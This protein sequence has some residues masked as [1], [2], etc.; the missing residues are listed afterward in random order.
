MSAPPGAARGGPLHVGIVCYPS[1]GG[2]GVVAAE[3]G[4]GLARRGHSVHFISYDAPFRL[5]GYMTQVAFHGVEVPNYPLFK[6][7]PYLLALAS[8]IIEVARTQGLDLVHAH[9]AIPH[10]VS[11]YLA[12]KA[13]SDRLCVI[14]T[15]HGTDT[16]L[17][18]SDPAFSPLVEFCIA[19][20]D[21]VTV[22]SEYLRRRTR[23]VFGVTRDIEVV[24]NFVDPAEYAA[25]PDPALRARFAAPGEAIVAHLS[26]F[27]PVKRVE[28]VVR[29]FA[30]LVERHP[31]RLLMIGDGP[32][33]PRAHE[34]AREL[35]VLGRI[36]F[37]G[38]VNCVAPLLAIADAFL[39]PSSEE[40]FGLSA[41]EA[42]ASGT[43][44]VASRVGGLPEVVV[45]GETGYLVTP[46]DEDGMAAA[47]ARIVADPG[48]GL[49]LGLCGRRRA[50][51]AFGAERWVG[52]YEAY[53][54]RVLEAGGG[55][56]GGAGRAG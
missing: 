23:E 56:G 32:G 34:L 28:A 52:A 44:V 18:G 26:N 55:G 2:S 8:K 48:L 15:L 22:V 19:E 14:T 21:G 39:L 10:A 45:D 51:E 11:C 5:Q 50:V 30:R 4:K 24:Y 17:V 36:S 16:T 7:P 53:Y 35:G 6:H 27:R 38:N 29:V 46:E 25:P 43:P 41:L 9:Y 20:S 13:L 42:M 47:L 37:L 3:L 31:A 12:K 1:Y 40:S 49:R 54:R 33:S